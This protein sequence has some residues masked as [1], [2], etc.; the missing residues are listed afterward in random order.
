M[1]PVAGAFAAAAA[2]LILAACA[3]PYHHGGP[4]YAEYD[5]YYDGYYGAYSGGY[6]GP[7]GY[8]YFS[9]GRG[10]YRRDD[11]RHFRH[12]RF[13]HGSPYRSRQHHRDD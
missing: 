10:D 5:V 2:A 6:W 12:E 3:A 1:K 13:E 4:A 7:D 11:G 8:F 9:N